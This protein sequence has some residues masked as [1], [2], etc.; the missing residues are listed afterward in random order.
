[1]SENGDAKTA[2]T[3]SDVAIGAG[4]AAVAV[5]AYFL[6]SAPSASSAPAALHV[7]PFV[8]RQQAGLAFEQAW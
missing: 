8:G 2:A 6:L 7:A 4:L 5:G 3:I 1:V